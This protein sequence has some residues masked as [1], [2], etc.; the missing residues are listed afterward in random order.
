MI[1]ALEQCQYILCGLL[2][3]STSGIDLV[4]TVR[5]E[6]PHLWISEFC[7]QIK[8]LFLRAAELEY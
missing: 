6:N 4:D 2:V 8:A 1:S 5:M 3:D 7:D